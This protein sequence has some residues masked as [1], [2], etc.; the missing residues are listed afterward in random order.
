[1][2][3]VSEFVEAAEGVESGESADWRRLVRRLCEHMRALLA[4]K[5]TLNVVARS[6]GLDFSGDV[7]QMKV[8][9]YASRCS[10]DIQAM[11]LIRELT[12]GEGESLNILC[13]NPDFG[14]GSPN[15]AVELSSE[16]W[17]YEPMRFGGDSLLAA[18]KAAKEG[19]LSA[20]LKF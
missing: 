5:D 7:S 2:V 13:P 15:Y 8:I 12:Q 4:V 3:S 9:S 10:L 18:L 1:M 17:D 6:L 19:V 16:A 20:E 14:A 11:A